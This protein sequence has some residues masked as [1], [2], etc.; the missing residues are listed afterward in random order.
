MQ[1]DALSRFSSD[2]VSDREDNHQVQVLGP[3]HFQTV[4]AT[5]HKPA[6]DSLGDCIHQASQREAEVIEGLKSIDKTACNA[7][8]GVCL[9]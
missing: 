9:T 1:A 3:Q 5:H 7:Q 2:H 4:A 8:L 6:S